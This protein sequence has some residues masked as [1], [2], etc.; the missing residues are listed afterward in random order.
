MA[1]NRTIFEIIA[2]TFG[3][4]KTGKDVNRLGA[5]MKRFAGTMI[6]AA[7]AYKAFTKGIEAMKLA[8]KLEGVEKGFNK[9]TASAGFT[10]GTLKKLKDATNGTVSSMDLMQQANQAM[11]LGVVDNNDQMADMFDIAQR[12]ASAL[13]QDTLYGVTSLTTGLGR[14]SKLML[15][16]VGI[17]VDVKKANERYAEANDLVV[18]KLTDAQRKQA[19][20]NE[21]LRQG[22]I[23]VDAL[24]EETLTS[25]DKMNQ[26][27]ASLLDFKTEIGAALIDSGVLDVMTELANRIK[28]V[29]EQQISWNQTFAE[30]SDIS[31]EQV[32]QYNKVSV[33]Q[34]QAGVALFNMTD[35]Q[36]KFNQEGGLTNK[37]LG[38]WA[39][40]LPSNE[41][42][43][44]QQILGQ[45]ISELN[46]YGNMWNWSEQAQL[47]NK[48]SLETL[49][50][51][52]T[53]V[54]HGLQQTKKGLIDEEVEIDANTE[55]A[56]KN[57]Q[58]KVKL[59]QSEK[60]IWEAMTLTEKA[61]KGQVDAD[62]ALGK[63][64][65][66][67]TGVYAVQDNLIKTGFLSAKQ[68]WELGYNIVKA[69]A[70]AAVVKTAKTIGYP[71]NIIPTAIQAAQGAA[72]V[73]AYGATRPAQY[74]F[75]G[76]VD[77]PTNFTVGEAG[78]EVVS[79]TPLEGVN[80]AGG[81]SQIIIN[82]PIISS[83]YVE[84]ELPELIAEAVRKGSD[85]GLS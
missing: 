3:F 23:L 53:D 60:A 82:N 19:F 78:A 84:E 76:V 71:M 11:L 79:V 44:L 42:S 9:M 80:N 37:Q 81:G 85:F 50:Q 22:Q 77:E 65:K 20:V 4:P 14:Q 49:I 56:I 35:L 2:K 10:V 5:T 73:R 40:A 29:V 13:G 21:G 39:D 43:L 38:A 15:D 8:A 33:M 57:Y 7:V 18:S 72:H 17:L 30:Q 54:A 62:T 47:S 46:D 55:A 70:I 36:K 64:K 32:E 31:E 28:N 63:T 12:L 51:V 74:G 26:L 59:A 67:L 27:S 45:N 41:L 66:D 6:S 61:T 48:I 1:Q 69:E 16:N 68:E 75:E 24:G 34:S 83:Q 58:A 52:Y 25:A